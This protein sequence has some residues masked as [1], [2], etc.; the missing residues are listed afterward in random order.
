MKLNTKNGTK[1]T[2]ALDVVQLKAKERKSDHFDVR[3]AI[4]IIEAHLAAILPKSAWTGLEFH[5]D[6]HAMQTSSHKYPSYSTQFTLMRGASAWFVTRVER[7]YVQNR[8]TMIR[9][10]NLTDKAAEIAA[11]ASRPF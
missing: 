9:P 7:A 6:P 10:I 2:A 5:V 4:T 1:I 11:Y 3:D 8:T